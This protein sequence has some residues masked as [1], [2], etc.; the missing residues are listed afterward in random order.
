[1][2]RLKLSSRLDKLH[3]TGGAMSAFSPPGSDVHVHSQGGTSMTSKAMPKQL[4]HRILASLYFCHWGSL[5][6][7][8]QDPCIPTA[9]ILNLQSKSPITQMVMLGRSS[10]PSQGPIFLMHICRN[11]ESEISAQRSWDLLL[12]PRGGH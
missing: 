6:P 1:M 10:S 4:L 2:I 5:H 9:L 8:T 11:T 12:T 7:N 3:M